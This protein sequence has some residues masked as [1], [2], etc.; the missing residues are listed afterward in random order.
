MITQI[1]IVP[2]FACNIRCSYCFYRDFDSKVTLSPSSLRK[3]L[4]QVKNRIGS[5]INVHFT[6]GEPL[7]NPPLLG[8]Y[9]NTISELFHVSAVSISTNGTFLIDAAMEFIKPFC[10]DVYVIVTIDAWE[11][12]KYRFFNNQPVIG[13]QI[14]ERISENRWYKVGIVTALLPSLQFSDYKRILSKALEK[15]IRYFELNFTK[16]FTYVDLDKIARLLFEIYTYIGKID[17]CELCGDWIDYIENGTV[18]CKRKGSGNSESILI[19][20]TSDIR[21][22]ELDIGDHQNISTQPEEC[23]YQHPQIAKT[24]CLLK[25]LK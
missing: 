9:L 23:I 16:G 7:I 19:L 5:S 24:C 12:S 4:I 11:V 14:L 22:C 3:V 20:P 10:S 15:N 8:E 18:Y 21:L 6:G 1:R 25:D 17:K 13:R 2:W